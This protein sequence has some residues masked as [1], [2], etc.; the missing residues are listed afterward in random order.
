MGCGTSGAKKQRPL[1][2][3][4]DT[5]LPVEIKGEVVHAMETLIPCNLMEPFLENVKEEILQL[6]SQL[7]HYLKDMS[8]KEAKNFIRSL[9]FSVKQ[10]LAP[11]NIRIID[12]NHDYAFMYVSDQG[13]YY[14]E[15]G[16][17][18]NGWRRRIYSCNVFEE[19]QVKEGLRHGGTY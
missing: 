4:N 10:V 3:V 13:V 14:L 2:P 15:E 12:I 8:P 1:I 6:R 18:L 9:R 16:A 17:Y 19:F 7:G 11:F 5:G